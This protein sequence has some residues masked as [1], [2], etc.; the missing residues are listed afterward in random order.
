MSDM[1]EPIPNDLPGRLRVFATK[2]LHFFV[3][4]IGDV[5]VQVRKNL[6]DEH[7]AVKEIA[8]LLTTPPVEDPLTV[9]H[10]IEDRLGVD[11]YDWPKYGQWI[12]HST[13][14]D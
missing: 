8:D 12:R 2:S 14:D 11:H 1:P 3:D 7:D 10:K 5:L 9:I 4:E 13:N 6:R